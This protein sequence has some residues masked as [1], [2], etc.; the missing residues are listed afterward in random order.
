M[1]IWSVRYESA[2]TGEQSLQ[3]LLRRHQNHP[4]DPRAI[5]DPWLRLSTRTEILAG[6]KLTYPFSPTDNTSGSSKRTWWAKAMSW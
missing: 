5:S 1:G 2:T 6:R 4:W 3:Y